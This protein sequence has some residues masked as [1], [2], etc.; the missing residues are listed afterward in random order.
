MGSFK[1]TALAGRSI[2][3]G[4]FIHMTFLDLEQ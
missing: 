2:G 4:K 3:L 1:F